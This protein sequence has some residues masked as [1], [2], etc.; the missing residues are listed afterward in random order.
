MVAADRQIQGV[1]LQAVELETAVQRLGGLGGLGEGGRGRSR[2]TLRHKSSLEVGFDPSP[3]RDGDLQHDQ[4]RGPEHGQGGG[5]L[6]VPCVG[7]GR[8]LLVLRAGCRRCSCRQPGSR[9]ALEK[10]PNWRCFHLCQDLHLRLGPT[11]DKEKQEKKRLR[12]HP[13]PHLLI[14][15]CKKKLAIKKD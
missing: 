11:V 7:N 3:A 1:N 2:C 15:P 6:E 12:N 10:S 9:T 8:G 13:F 5:S 4:G 14:P